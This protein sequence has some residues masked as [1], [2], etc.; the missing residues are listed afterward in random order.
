MKTERQTFIVRTSQ[1]PVVEIDPEAGAVYV[2]FKRG[3]IART[4]ARPA[5]SMHLAVDLDSQGEVIG[6]E[7]VGID[8][9]RLT[10][11]LRMADVQAPHVDLAEARFRPAPVPA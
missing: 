7:A 9:F 4:V 11:L 1:P 2:R 10:Q 5:R 3:R 8:E 6:I